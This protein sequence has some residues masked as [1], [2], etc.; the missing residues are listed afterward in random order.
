M[1]HAIKEFTILKP[2]WMTF[3]RRLNKLQ[4]SRLTTL[5]TE[6][7]KP[8]IFLSCAKTFQERKFCLLNN[9]FPGDVTE[10]GPKDAKNTLSS[11]SWLQA[12]PC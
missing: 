3:N 9:D 4:S 6:K 2:A 12:P 8:L 11:P 7:V 1:Q 5:L 10:S